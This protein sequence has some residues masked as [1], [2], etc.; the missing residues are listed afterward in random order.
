MTS[1]IDVTADHVAVQKF[2]SHEWFCIP[3]AGK[4]FLHD[5]RELIGYTSPSKPEGD[6][7]YLTTRYGKGDYQIKVNVMK[8]RAIWIYANNNITPPPGYQIDHINGNKQD[9][10]IGNLRAVTPGENM[11]NPNTITRISGENNHNSKLT[12]FQRDEIYRRVCAG[13]KQKDLA[14][15]YGVHKSNISNIYC[16]RRA[17][18]AKA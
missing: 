16:T 3:E 13:E 15:E 9:N 6:Y 4:I 5:G 18:E 7:L 1:K 11:R 17:K 2:L 14:L 8:A 12:N 10:R